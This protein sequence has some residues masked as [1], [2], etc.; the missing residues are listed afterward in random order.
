MAETLEDEDI[1][2]EAVVTQEQPSKDTDK[3][4]DEKERNWRAFLDKRKEEQEELKKEKERSAQL[5]QEN[6]RRSKEIEDMKVAFS[7]LLQKNNDPV[8]EDDDDTGKKIKEEVERIINQRDEQR[9]KAE[10]QRRIDEER[11]VIK[12][13][14]PDL[15]E[16]CSQDNLAYLEFYHPEIAIPL[17]KMQDGFEKTKLAYDAIKKHVKMGKKEEKLIEKNL[18]KPKS[19]HSNVSNESQQE[20]SSYSMSDS[21]KQQVWNKMQRLISG[22]D[23]D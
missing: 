22:E 8:Y 19:V 6:A 5:A 1:K 13:D 11:K 17:S 23:E 12:R 14:M 16:V 7:A 2:T 18:S 10:E 4:E 21:K 20:G 9:A 3:V 15:L